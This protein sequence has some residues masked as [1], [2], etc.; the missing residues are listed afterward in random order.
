MTTSSNN[1]DRGL[2][3]QP[4]GADA[5]GSNLADAVRAWIESPAAASRSGV[6]PRYFASTLNMLPGVTLPL[7]SM[8][9]GGVGAQDRQLL[10]SPVATHAEQAALGAGPLTLLAPSLLHHLQLQPAIERYRPVALWGPP[11]LA[12]KKPNLAPMLTF[13]RDP[14]PYDDLLSYVVVEGAPRRNEVVFFHRPSRTIYTADLFFN[15]QQPQGLLRSIPLRLMGVYRR[16]GVSKLWKRWV[17]DRAAFGR[18]LDQILAWDFDRVVMSHGD[19]LDEHAH[20]RCEI[21]LRELALID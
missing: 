17:T 18:S 5:T 6:E 15:L 9:V 10:I 20:D 3:I 21:A 14:W 7:R 4:R 2:P 11:G 12:E 8:L 19:P 13:G 16:F 1:S